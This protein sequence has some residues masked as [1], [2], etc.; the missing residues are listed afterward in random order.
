MRDGARLP[1]VQRLVEGQ[2]DGN[3]EL[4]LVTKP[5]FERTHTHTHTHT[6]ARTHARDAARTPSLVFRVVCPEVAVRAK[7]TATTRC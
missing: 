3:V 1:R 5:P 2:C 7:Q 4:V 6:H